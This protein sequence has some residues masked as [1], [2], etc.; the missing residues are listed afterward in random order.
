MVVEKFPEVELGLI[1]TPIDSTHTWIIIFCLLHI[2]YCVHRQTMLLNIEMLRS[3][4][5][6]T[7]VK[8][9]HVL[10]RINTL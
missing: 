2:T 10:P 9:I 1:T 7:G 5:Y 4:I 8:Q 6:T 3:G